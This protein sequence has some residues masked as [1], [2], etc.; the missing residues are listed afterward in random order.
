MSAT[1]R[2]QAGA[3]LL[4]QL[5]RV[6]STE[7]GALTVCRRSAGAGC[8]DRSQRSWGTLARRWRCS[9]HRQAIPNVT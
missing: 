4:A 7:G 3:D 5:V 2:H 1:G 8:P 9:L 6:H